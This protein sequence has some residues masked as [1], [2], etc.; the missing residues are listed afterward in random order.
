MTNHAFACVIGQM[1]VKCQILREK[2]GDRNDSVSI[3]GTT[4]F[5]LER[6]RE[7]YTKKIEQGKF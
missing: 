6:N 3:N 7:R 5:D 2:V 1:D 4:S